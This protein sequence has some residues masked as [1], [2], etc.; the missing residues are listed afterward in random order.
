MAGRI[1]WRDIVHISLWIPKSTV[2]DPIECLKLKKKKNKQNRN[3]LEQLPPGCC[4]T[5]PSL[6]RC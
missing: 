3:N 2:Q 1:M 6:S 5:L 4:F